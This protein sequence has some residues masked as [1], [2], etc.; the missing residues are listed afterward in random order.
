MRPLLSS[1]A[2]LSTLCAPIG[3][4]VYSL[5]HPTATAFEFVLY[6]WE[7]ALGRVFGRV[8]TLTKVSVP[9]DNTTGMTSG[10]RRSSALPPSMLT[11]S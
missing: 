8:G 5:P 3:T 1:D 7:P 6:E 4:V 10:G 9:T 2:A 11:L